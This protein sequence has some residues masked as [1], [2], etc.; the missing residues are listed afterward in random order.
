MRLAD[1][2][3]GC[4]LATVASLVLGIGG[5]VG[6]GSSSVVGIT[7]CG[8]VL[9][10]PNLMRGFTI[11]ISVFA[12]Y[13]YLTVTALAISMKLKKTSTLY[14]LPQYQGLIT[15]LLIMIKI[16]IMAPPLRLLTPHD[17]LTEEGGLYRH[18]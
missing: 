17:T 16:K 18:L 7:D 13:Y 3:R 14:L 1:W 10:L 4:S 5:D 6:H 8:L 12:S 2:Y 9:V 11:T 15:Q